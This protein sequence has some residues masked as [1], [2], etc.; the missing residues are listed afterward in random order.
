LSVPLTFAEPVVEPFERIHMAK[1]NL[2][3]RDPRSRDASPIHI[4]IRWGGNRLVYPSGERILPRYWST[5]SQSAKS[6]L[7]GYATFNLNLQD[8]VAKALT[9]HQQ[10]LLDNDQRQPTVPQLRERIDAIL[11]PKAD[12]QPRSLFTFIDEQVELAKVRMDNG[13]LSG[14][15]TLSKYRTAREHLRNFCKA[16]K[17]RLDFDTVDV[18]FYQRFMAYMV[19]DLG[20]ARN[21]VG[22]Y[23]RT[24]KTWLNAAQDENPLLLPKYRSRRFKAPT[25]ATHKAYLTAQELHDLF[26]LDLSDN[27][28]LEQVRDLFIVGAWTGLRFSDW[29]SIT[30]EDIAD[31]RI[32]IATTQKTKEAV[33]IPVHACVRAI[34]AKY[35]NALPPVISNQKTNAYLKEVAAMVPSLRTVM[36]G[37]PKAEQVATHTARRSFASNAFRGDGYTGPV[38]VSTIMA[39]TGHRTEKAFRTYICLDADEHAN[40]FAKYMT[41]D[42][43]LAIVA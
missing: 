25:E 42:A 38:P 39:I 32:R 21:T 7:S 27:R 40:E 23:I 9:A 36:F 14:I 30:P 2:N 43:P 28:R 11:N 34:L 31:N 12:E 5:K 16:K 6:G 15:A 10:F 8:K 41:Q 3:L 13:E 22:K 33:T 26:H 18:A 4:V 19:K 1:A 29:A 24:L 35:G 37:R 20:L 17:F